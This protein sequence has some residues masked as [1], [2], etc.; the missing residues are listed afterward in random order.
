MSLIP[1]F[2]YVSDGVFELLWQ[3]RCVACDMPGELLCKECCRGLNKGGP[4]QIAVLRLALLSA[5]S[6]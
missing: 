1:A 6:V 3:T 5:R 2:H 4:V